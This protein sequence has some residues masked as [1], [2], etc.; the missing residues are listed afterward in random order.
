[1]HVIIYL[2]IGF[3]I[4]DA[5]LFIN[6]YADKKNTKLKR[7]KWLYYKDS[8]DRRAVAFALVLFWPGIIGFGALLGFITLFA[9]VLIFIVDGILKMF[10]KLFDKLIPNQDNEEKSI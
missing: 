8:V 6:K 9:G 3:F 2:L 10:D 4:A 1:M 7:F 5:F